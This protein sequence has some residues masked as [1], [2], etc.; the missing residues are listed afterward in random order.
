MHIVSSFRASKPLWLAR[1]HTC[2]LVHVGERGCDLLDGG[3][4]DD[5]KSGKRSRRDC[6]RQPCCQGMGWY[7][8]VR[9]SV[10]M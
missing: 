7:L 3:K 1:L 6:C 10:Y 8:H 9:L 2:E 5:V 4:G